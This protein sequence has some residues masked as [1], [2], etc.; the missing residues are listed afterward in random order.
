MLEKTWEAIE[1]RKNLKAK[2]NQWKL[3]NRNQLYKHSIQK[4]TKKLKKE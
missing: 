1:K 2:L 4:W 3:D